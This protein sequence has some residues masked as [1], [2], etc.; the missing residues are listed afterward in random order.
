[1]TSRWLALAGLIV[2]LA[3]C[4]GDHG[5][6]AAPSTTSI[7]RSSA[8]VAQLGPRPQIR[9]P[10]L[11]R[12]GQSRS[13]SAESTGRR[14]WPPSSAAVSSRR[15]FSDSTTSNRPKVYRKLWFSPIARR[16]RRSGRWVFTP[17]T[18]PPRLT[19]LISPRILI[20]PDRNTQGDSFA[21]TR[22]GITMTL[23]AF[24]S[25]TV[26][27]CCPDLHFA[28]HWK[29]NGGSYAGSPAGIV[30]P[31]PIA[32]RAIASSSKISVGQSVTFAVKV[33][34]TGS[35][36]L[37]S[38]V[39]NGVTLRPGTGIDQ[40]TCGSAP[41]CTIGTLGPATTATVT[42]RAKVTQHINAYLFRINVNGI[43]PTGAVNVG[44]EPKIAAAADSD[45]TRPLSEP[46]PFGGD[47]HE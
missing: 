40:P 33:T 15:R 21:V 24:S 9:P 23:A 17:L 11:A 20:D 36:P 37:T 43:F 47:R 3:A 44:V 16:E 41:E 25:L 32:V 18:R 12:P 8:T 14:W 38:T 19:R 1:M 45:S 6:S 5:Q 10:L 46:G 26:P 34:N 31:V 4:S 2:V 29:W 13:L 42:I 7:S 39:V 28:V 30:G 27:A 22:S 35:V